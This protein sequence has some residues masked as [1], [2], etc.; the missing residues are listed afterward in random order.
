MDN[1]EYAKC[2]IAFLDM[3]GFKNIIGQS[4]CEDICT[5]FDNIKKPFSSAQLDEEHLITEDTIKALNIK[6]MSDSIC[7][8]IEVKHAN[9]LIALLTSF[10]FIKKQLPYAYDNCQLYA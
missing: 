8:Y 4:I 3:L 10:P 7:F 2:Y 1:R 5:V 9:A 6:V